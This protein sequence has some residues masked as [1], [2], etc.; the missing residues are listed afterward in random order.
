M[1]GDTF[2]KLIKFYSLAVL[3]TVIGISTLLI[4]NFVFGSKFALG[5]IILSNTIV[6]LVAHYI[7]RKF[8]WDSKSP[9][10]RELV[11]FSATYIPSFAFSMICFFSISIFAGLNYVL[12]QVLSSAI[13]SIFAFFSQKYLVFRKGK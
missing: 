5:N 2:Q 3:N 9:Y 8:I 4:F 13:F 6:Q 1:A 12:V 10:F 11:K 7:T